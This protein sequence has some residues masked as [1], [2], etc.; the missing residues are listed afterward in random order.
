[1]VAGRGRG[2]IKTEIFAII[3]SSIDPSSGSL[4]SRDELRTVVRQMR[5]KLCAVQPGWCITC[6]CKL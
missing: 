5:C 3:F 2:Q 1:M 6:G 4:H